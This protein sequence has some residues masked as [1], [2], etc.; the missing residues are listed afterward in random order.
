MAG[1]YGH[2]H[3]LKIAKSRALVQETARAN[4]R[5]ILDGRRRA[6]THHAKRA[7]VRGAA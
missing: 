3:F 5:A 4:L 2:A 6:F 1:L 7:V